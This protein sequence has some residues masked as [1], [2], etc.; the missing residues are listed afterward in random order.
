MV[1]VRTGLSHASLQSSTL[2][3][4]LQNLDVNT[5]NK[6]SSIDERLPDQ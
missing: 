4:M 6:L 3:N 1:L 5:L 2:A